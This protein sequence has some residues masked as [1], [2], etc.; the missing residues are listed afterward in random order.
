[1]V[2]GNPML[3]LHTKMKRLT[4]TLTNWSK[5]EYGYVFVKFMHCEDVVRNA[6]ELS[7]HDN[8]KE[9]RENLHAFN[10]QYIRYLKMEYAI[11]QQ[12]QLTLVKRR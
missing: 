6:K 12:T 8:K 1:M 10:A 7:L 3:R 2:V 11:H 5:R 9:N 4:S